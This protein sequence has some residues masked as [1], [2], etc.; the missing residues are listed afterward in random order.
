MATKTSFNLAPQIVNYPIYDAECIYFN[1]A[2]GCML[3]N[4]CKYKH[5]IHSQPSAE[6]ILANIHKQKIELNKQTNDLLK[7]VLKILEF[8]VSKLK[9]IAPITPIQPQPINLSMANTHS[10]MDTSP[11][12]TTTAPK[13]ITTTALPTKKKKAN[14]SKRKKNLN[15]QRLLLKAFARNTPTPPPSK[16][17]AIVDPTSQYFE[18]EKLNSHI[19]Q[20][21]ENKAQFT[22]WILNKMLCHKMD[23]SDLEKLITIIVLDGTENDFIITGNAHVLKIESVLQQFNYKYRK[24]FN[25]NNLDID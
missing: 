4:R 1:T 13:V 16:A 15:K 6:Q 5:V 2:T 22:E 3:Q 10:E 25:L 24:I 9:P 19:I 17:Q 21:I 20:T 18:E 12:T 14:K 23:K 11:K 8:A 7:S